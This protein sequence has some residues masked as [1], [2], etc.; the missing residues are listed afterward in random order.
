MA[1]VAAIWPHCPNLSAGGSCRVA[2]CISMSRPDLAVPQKKKKKWLAA[3]FCRWRLGPADLGQNLAVSEGVG[4]WGGRCFVFFFI[5]SLNLG[6]SYNHTIEIKLGQKTISTQA[7]RN[8]FFC[9][10]KLIYIYIYL[11]Q[12]RN[13][14]FHLIHES[15]INAI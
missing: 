7:E 14:F 10:H 8:L 5:I 6:H 4:G 13:F 3:R 12:Q 1:L 2:F 9:I 11:P 15:S